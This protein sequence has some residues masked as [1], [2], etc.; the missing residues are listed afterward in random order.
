MKGWNDTLAQQLNNG[1]VRHRLLDSM[2]Q[3][4]VP[5]TTKLDRHRLKVSNDLHWP[6]HVRSSKRLW[7]SFS[8]TA[9]KASS[10]KNK[11]TKNGSMTGCVLIGG[12]EAGWSESAEVGGTAHRPKITRPYVSS[13]STPTAAPRYMLR[14]RRGEETQPHR[15]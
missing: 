3:G 13:A 7:V 1:D 8:N 9:C 6:T 11:P 14:A 12:L 4:L 10:S 15:K 5:S 2:I